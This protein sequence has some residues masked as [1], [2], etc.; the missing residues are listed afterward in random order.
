MFP[1]GLLCS[2]AVGGG[3]ELLAWEETS[4]AL[5]RTGPDL[6]SSLWFL[7]CVPVRV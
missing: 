1:Q 4:P 3:P 6:L 7:K 2:P 5:I